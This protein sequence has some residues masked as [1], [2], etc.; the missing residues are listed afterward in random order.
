MKSPI[1]N[2]P[3]VMPKGLVFLDADLRVL[4]AD[5]LFYS[6]FQATPAETEGR[7]LKEL[8]NG[9]WSDPALHEHLRKAVAEEHAFADHQVTFDLPNR[10]G[11]RSIL[12][13]GGTTGN[14]EHPGAAVMLGFEDNTAR[15]VAQEVIRVAEVRYRRLFQTAKDGILILDAHS[16]QVIDANAFMEGLVGLE[17]GELLGKQLHEIGMF[18]DIEQNKAA[19][20][21]LQRARYIRYEHLPVQNRRGGT[22]EVEFIDN[23][24][25]EGER[26]VAQCNVRDISERVRLEKQVVMQAMSLADEARSKDQFLAM[27]SHELRN[28]LAPIRSA[29]HL[30]KLQRGKEMDEVERQALDIIERQVGNMTGLV[31]ELLEVSRVING[32]IHL[33]LCAV[34]MHQVLEHA[35]ETVAPLFVKYRHSHLLNACPHPLWVDADPRRLEEVFVN[36]LTNAA[37]YTPEGGHIEVACSSSDD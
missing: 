12:V 16:G 8:G 24:Y 3:D 27:L 5:S 37:K 26:L 23:V 36:L 34:E 6:S 10:L 30:L 18:K 29:V 32:R 22:V 2:M 4:S 35:M 1:A 7:F 20:R 21:E 13:H 31:S 17:T 11:F 19:F 33:S 14:T 9:Q 25:L 28:P 15:S